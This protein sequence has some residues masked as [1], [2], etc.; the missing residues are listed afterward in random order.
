MGRLPGR[1]I[2]KSY[3]LSREA[4]IRWLDQPAERRAPNKRS[5][6]AALASSSKGGGPTG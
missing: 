5:R 4:L 1:K 3:R 2:G 6:R